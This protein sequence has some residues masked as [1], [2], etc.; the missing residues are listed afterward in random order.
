MG[1]EVGVKV[2]EK[3]MER[4]KV[5]L[6]GEKGVKRGLSVGVGPGMT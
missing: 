2:R 6:V 3:E 1:G 4:E 5:G